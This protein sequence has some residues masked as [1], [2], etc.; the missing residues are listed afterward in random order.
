MKLVLAFA[1]L[2]APLGAFAEGHCGHEASGYALER[3]KATEP[4]S[5]G[6][7]FFVVPSLAGR[8][9]RG[10]RS[11]AWQVEVGNTRNGQR[12]SSVVYDVRVDL[13]SCALL[14]LWKVK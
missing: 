2:F 3:F 6:D 5:P 1:A 9:N 14:A 12:V 7:L 4:R 11:E 10:D 8:P 13:V